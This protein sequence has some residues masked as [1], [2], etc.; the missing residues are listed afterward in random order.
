MRLDEDRL[1][2]REEFGLETRRA[3]ALVLIGRPAAQPG[4]SQDTV[5][6]VLRTVASHLGRIEVLT[7]KE[8]LDHA[9][10]ALGDDAAS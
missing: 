9:E 8:L 6:G 5:N 4:M 1:R 3:R 2:I 10:R 7:Y